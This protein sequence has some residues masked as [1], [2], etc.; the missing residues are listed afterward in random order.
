MVT[1]RA[2]ERFNF[3]KVAGEQCAG[4]ANV[5]VSRE[6]E[7]NVIASFGFRNPRRLTNVALSVVAAVLAFTSFVQSAEPEVSLGSANFKPSI[8]RPFGWRGDGS[9]RFPGATPV[10]EWSATKNVRWKTEVGKSYSS[11]ILSER[12]A[13][14][15]SEPNLLVC[16]NR[17][18]GK[19]RWQ[20]KVAP[21]DLADPKSRQAAEDYKLPK[22]GSGMAAA[23]PI[24]DGRNVYAVFADGLVCAVDFDGRRVWTVCIDAEQITGYGRSSSPIIV[25]GKLIVHMTN[26]YAFDPATGKQL[27]VDADAKS[28]YGTPTHLM[29]GSTEVI[30]TP[31]GD[32][33]RVSDG[34]GLDSGMGMT[35]RP[36]PVAADGIIYFVDAMIS[37]VRLTSAFKDQ[38]VWNAMISGEVL[39]SPLLHDGKLFF[40]SSEGELF[41]FDAK[42]S[43]S[44]EPSI[45]AR[46]LFED[47][48]GYSS[49]TFAGKY[50]FLNSNAG[51]IV[52]L[53]ATPEAKLVQKNRLPAGSGSSPVFSGKEMYL[54]DGIDLY[55]I[56]E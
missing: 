11:P 40:V 29:V 23:T 49:L 21:A 9:G 34:K 48:G 22:D 31:A 6:W 54:R 12:Y 51:E 27:W 38:E 50:L 8:D 28:T 4:R 16:I 53:E 36:S 41:A 35:S 1:A 24:T 20:T 25:G 18:D 47:G 39:G 45:A 44:Q 42:G 56:S 3:T 43:G 33:V 55:C 46:S 17:A 26:L 10:I 13:F 14:V 32:A 15:T 7:A 2:L 19:V 37:A 5:L 30:V 52:V